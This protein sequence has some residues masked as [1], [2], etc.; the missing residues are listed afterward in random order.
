LDKSEAR[1]VN[2]IFFGYAS[3]SWAYRVLNHETNQI[4]ETCEVTFDE[5]HRSEVSFS[6]RQYRER[7]DS[8][9]PCTHTWPTSRYFHQNLDQATFTRL[10]GELG[11]CL[12]SWVSV[13]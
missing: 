1:S 3:H 10:M 4:M 11:V 5:T 7:E 2:G 9:D 6:E 12:I 8:L 13:W